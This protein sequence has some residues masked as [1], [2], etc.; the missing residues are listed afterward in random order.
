MP[1]HY[2]PVKYS[3]LFWVD[4]AHLTPLE[5]YIYPQTRAE[6]VFYKMSQVSRGWQW[7]MMVAFP[8]TCL[9]ALETHVLL[10]FLWSIFCK[11]P[12]IDVNLLTFKILKKQNT[13]LIRYFT[14]CCISEIIW[15]LNVWF[16]RKHQIFY[17]LLKKAGEFNC[18][19]TIPLPFPWCSCRCIF[20]G[21]VET[22]VIPLFPEMKLASL[23]I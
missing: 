13:R 19:L 7:Y 3:D 17:C 1:A 12:A 10:R 4:F 9:G 23:L 15:A 21:R 8:G 16:N 18:S 14:I 5:K 11:W 6:I 2:N 20:L 22:F